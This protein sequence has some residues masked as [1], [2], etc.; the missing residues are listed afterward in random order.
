LQFSFFVFRLPNPL[1]KGNAMRPI[2]LVAATLEAWERLSPLQRDRFFRA[3]VS[4]ALR[5]DRVA[6][7]DWLRKRLRN[8]PLAE[9]IDL[10]RFAISDADIALLM[11][12]AREPP[13]EAAAGP[14]RDEA[15]GG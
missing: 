8:R 1:F 6:M 11:R 3:F 7:R 5:L 9:P 13:G 14:D 10:A 4:A 12:A 2:D 15:N